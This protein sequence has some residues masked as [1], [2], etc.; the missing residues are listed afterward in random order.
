[1]VLLVPALVVDPLVPVVVL[2]AVV[3][4]W[5]KVGV[6]LPVVPEAEVDEV[7][8]AVLVAEPP[9]GFVGDGVLRGIRNSAAPRATATITAPTTT[10]IH[11]FDMCFPSVVVR[12]WRV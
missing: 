1:L 11:F 3:E 9:L 10:A 5:V 8:D 6:V 4:P 2:G 12:T 7:F